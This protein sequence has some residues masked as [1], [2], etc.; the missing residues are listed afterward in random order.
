MIGL[1]VYCHKCRR[2]VETKLIG[3]DPDSFVSLDIK[4]LQVFCPYCGQNNLKVV[5]GIYEVMNGI[6]RVVN[7]YGESPDS[8]RA[9]NQIFKDAIAA[10]MPA[11]ELANLITSE[12]KPLKKYNDL[13]RDNPTLMI[14]IPMIIAGLMQLPSYYPIV[15]PPET[16]KDTDRIIENQKINNQQLIEVLTTLRPPRVI[17]TLIIK[18]Q[19]NRPNSK[20]RQS[21]KKSKNR[22]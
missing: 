18:K 5:D 4:D 17:K 9:I 8:L 21:Y 2:W 7:S 10:Q 19:T 1:P 12:L 20:K 11:G 14:M 6:A 22:P 3:I 13:L 16:S 15:F